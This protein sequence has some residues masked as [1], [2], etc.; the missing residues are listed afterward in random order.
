MST[1]AGLETCLKKKKKTAS[2][3]GWA[4]VALCVYREGGGGGRKTVEL[5]LPGLLPLVSVFFWKLSAA[6]SFKEGERESGCSRG[7]CVAQQ[8]E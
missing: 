4:C 2:R 7:G 8:Y 6:A 5:A 3:S 1:P